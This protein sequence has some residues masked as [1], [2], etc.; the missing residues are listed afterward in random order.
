MQ[1]VFSPK[2]APSYYQ[3]LLSFGN[4]LT[5]E[6]LATREVCVN[7][8]SQNFCERERD[9]NIEKFSS[10]Q[11]ILIMVNMVFDLFKK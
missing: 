1:Q 3:L 10:Y 4:D 9:I 7:R 5:D 6:E 8:I 2:L 11:T